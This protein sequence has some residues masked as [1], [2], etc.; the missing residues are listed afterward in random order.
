MSCCLPAV[1]S[2]DIITLMIVLT[3]ATSP[4]PDDHLLR[5][6]GRLPPPPAQME[7]VQVLDPHRSLLPHS[8]RKQSSCC[9]HRCTISVLHSTSVCYVILQK[10][11]KEKMLL[12][13]DVRPAPSLCTL[14]APESDDV[15]SQKICACRE[16]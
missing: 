1:A 9:R 6:S 8:R 5:P 14:S 11:E 10:K 15:R 16:I 12:I 4:P 7:A 13:R 3:S 2:L